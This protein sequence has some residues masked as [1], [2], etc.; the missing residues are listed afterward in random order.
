[1]SEKRNGMAERTLAG[2]AW[3]S[4]AVGAQAAMQLVAL[5]LLARLLPPSS[6]GVFAAALVVIGFCAIFSD[7]GVGPAIVQRLKLEARHIRTGFTLSLL[8]SLAA[9]GVIWWVAP[10]IAHFFYI[11]DLANLVRVISIG[12]P[13]QGVSTVAQSMAQRDLRFGWLAVVD[14][15]AFT[16]GF[17]LIAPALAWIGYDVW[18]LAGAYLAQQSLR[19]V[20]LLMGQ[21]HL[22]RPLL[23]WSATKELLY[24]G[25]GSSLARVG[26][27]LAIQGD[28]LVVG[29]FLGPQALGL[30]SHAY[31]LMA[32]PAV[33]FGQVLDRVL[34]PT[35]ALVQL[36]TRRLARAYR[37]GISVCALVMLP[38]SIIVTIIADEIVLALL[39]SAWSGVATPLRIL[40]LGMLFRTSYKMS[41]SLVRATGAVYS[42]AWRQ[43]IF[44]S[45]VIISTTIGQ[46]WG[47]G[48]VATGVFTALGLNFALMAQLSLRLAAMSWTEFGRAHVPGLVLAIVLGFCTWVLA[49]WSRAQGATPVLLLVQTGLFASMLGMLLCWLMPN[50]FL[51]ENA[52]PIL[53]ALGTLLPLRLQRRPL[54]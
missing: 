2:L 25:G 3:T 36:E 33:L 42:R 22:K 16:A 35:M 1:V 26:N 5:I 31:Q 43:A 37:S 17:V 34:F 6:F 14:A 30:Y 10:L 12:L 49:D 20:M 23:E 39:G 21:P 50:F 9:A 7:L 44:A 52:Q 46:F 48:G 19:A 28:N 41:D 18:S 45:A 54:G 32:A 51:G 13:L 11:P 29:R 27:F 40:A 4:L 24:F 8:F 38:A 15:S 53:R 47:I